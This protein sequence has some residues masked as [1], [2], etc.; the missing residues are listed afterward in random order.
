MHEEYHPEY[1]ITSGPL[2]QPNVRLLKGTGAIRRSGN[3]VMDRE[4]IFIGYGS[5]FEEGKDIGTANIEDIAPT[6]YHLLG[7]AIPDDLD[8]K[9]ITEA[10]S[11]ELRNKEPKYY[12]PKPPD[13][14]DKSVKTS[15]EED[16]SI[17]Q[18]LRDMGYLTD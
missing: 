6:I 15:A 11:D 14:P 4:G 5:G 7:C 17:K 13:R 2:I 8:G 9:I 1:I 12:K 16:E 18:Q 3:H 10:L